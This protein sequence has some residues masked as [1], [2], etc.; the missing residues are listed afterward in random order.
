VTVTGAADYET[1]PA[2]GVR[3]AN[4]NF[5]IC[6]H[7]SVGV[8]RCAICNPERNIGGAL[9]LELNGDCGRFFGFILSYFLNFELDV[10]STPGACVQGAPAFLRRERQAGNLCGR[11]HLVSPRRPSRPRLTGEQL[12]PGKLGIHTLDERIGFIRLAA[13]FAA[14]CCDY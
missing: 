1:D 5:D 14:R 10:A 12:D 13:V 9:I 7:A 4:R 6:R 8:D 3:A 11:P 2:P